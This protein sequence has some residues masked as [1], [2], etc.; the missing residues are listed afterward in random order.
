MSR[1]HV[2]EKRVILPDPKYHNETVAKFINHVMESGKK[3]VAERM[4]MVIGY[5]PTARRIHP[6]TILQSLENCSDT[7]VKSRR[8]GG[9]HYRFHRTSSARRMALPCGWQSTVRVARNE[10]TMAAR[11]ARN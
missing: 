1:R 9:P 6:W 2:S 8:V 5:S 11:L 3:A 10:K 7:E 4:F